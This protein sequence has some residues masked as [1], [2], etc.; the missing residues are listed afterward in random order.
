MRIVEPLSTGALYPAIVAVAPCVAF[1]AAAFFGSASGAVLI[2]EVLYDPEGY[3]TGREFV[4]LIN[5]G[6]EA[7]SLK[8]WSINAGDGARV[9]LWKRAWSGGEGDSIA[10]GG[11][12]LIGGEDVVGIDSEAEL[13][14]Q[15]GPDGCALIH[16]GSVAD[17]LGWGAHQFAGYY[18]GAPAPDPASG[19]SLSRIPDG[20][21]TGFN[22]E[23]FKAGD[24]TPGL[25]NIR[26]RH[27]L[28]AG[29]VLRIAPVN[30]ET[31]ECVTVR[32]LIV[33]D[34]FDLGW[35]GLFELG[36]ELVDIGEGSRIYLPTAGT[37]VSPG[38]TAEIVTEWSPNRRGAF[39]VT[40]TL[41]YEGDSGPETCAATGPLRVGAGP[42]IINE[43]MFD[44]AVGGEWIEISNN[45]SDTVDLTGWSL[46]DR[47][48]GCLE[49]VR[50]LQVPPGGYALVAQ[51]S[52]SLVTYYG[53]IDPAAVVGSY[54]GRW[55]SLN[56]TDASDGRADVITLSD[57]SGMPSD[58]AAYS[59]RCGGGGVSAERLRSDLVG[60]RKD[61]WNASVATGGSTPGRANSARAGAP[62]GN[63]LLSVSPDVLSRDGGAPGR[64][65]ISYELPFRPASLRISLYSMDGREVSRLVDVSNGPARGSVLWDGLGAEGDRLARGAYILILSGTGEGGRSAKAKAVLAIK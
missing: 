20:H 57:A 56:N 12:F 14:L 4:E 11:L 54:A 25:F 44:P 30:P 53:G 26:R 17:L 28:F 10:P 18:E 15:N 39:A 16:D 33:S 7:I 29:R 31:Y 23:D 8:G 62:V 27:L 9:D 35:P 6:S 36:I 48:G 58:V 42:V 38:D 64:A 19:F 61:N 43:I 46:C 59:G 47:A 55:M 49:F 21:D 45:G 63:E 50:S 65:A 34:G 3:D 32:A 60:R 37:S 52:S 2:N 5:T 40:A 22:A 51:D 24:P 13:S 41:R 1:A